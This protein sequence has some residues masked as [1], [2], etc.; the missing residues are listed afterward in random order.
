[1]HDMN[2]NNDDSIINFYDKLK[3]DHI[4]HL[5]YHKLQMRNAGL[6]FKATF[7]IVNADQ[8]SQIIDLHF[9]LME[10]ADK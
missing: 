8:R 2:F 3:K 5:K 10:K 1:M 9:E 7:D 6:F 4:N